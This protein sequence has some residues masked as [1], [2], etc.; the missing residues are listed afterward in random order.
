MDPVTGEIE[1]RGDLEVILLVD[2]TSGDL[3]ATAYAA[4]DGWWRGRDVRG[5][6]RMLFPTPG[7]ADPRL[8]VA[9]RLT[10]R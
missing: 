8:D 4:D 5:N 6:V 9:E 10:R 7:A 1:V 3:L 2:R